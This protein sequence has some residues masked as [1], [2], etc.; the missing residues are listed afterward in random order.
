MVLTNKERGGGGE[1]N[2]GRTDLDPSGK[3]KDGTNF[4]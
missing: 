4:V 3:A 1:R 2:N